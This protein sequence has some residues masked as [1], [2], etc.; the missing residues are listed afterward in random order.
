MC[1]RSVGVVFYSPGWKQVSQ[2]NSTDRD[3]TEWSSV[4][5]EEWNPAVDAMVTLMEGAHWFFK[6]YMRLCQGQM[7]W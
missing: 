7:A 6:A 1:I 4:W 3:I 5:M 2:I